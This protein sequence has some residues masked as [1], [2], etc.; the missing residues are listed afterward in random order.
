MEIILKYIQ[1]LV[2]S[3]LIEVKEEEEEEILKSA[4]R[5]HILSTVCHHIKALT[6]GIW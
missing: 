1:Q 5:N 4:H 2:I 3:S 6:E